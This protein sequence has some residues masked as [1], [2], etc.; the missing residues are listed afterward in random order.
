MKNK[1]IYIIFGLLVLVSSVFAVTYTINVDSDT[2][3]VI[4]DKATADKTTKEA[5]II[6]YINTAIEQDNLKELKQEKQKLEDFYWKIDGSND[7]ELVKDINEYL[8]CKLNNVG[9]NI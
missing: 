6:N 2:D 5:T 9:C 4:S 3:K 8:D 1:I 7:I